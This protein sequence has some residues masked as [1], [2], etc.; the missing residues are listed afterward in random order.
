MCYPCGADPACSSGWGEGGEE[1]MACVGGEG[2]KQCA[3][4]MQLQGW[5]SIAG[6]A[7]RRLGRGHPVWYPMRVQPGI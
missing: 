4:L 3:A 1:G 6:G 7:A 2:G 5:H